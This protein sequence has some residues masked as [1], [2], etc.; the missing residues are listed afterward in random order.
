MAEALISGL[1]FNLNEA[2]QLRA[3]ALTGVGR[4][5]DQDRCGRER[6]LD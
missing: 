1:R 5:F 4:D 2:D 6:L 3:V